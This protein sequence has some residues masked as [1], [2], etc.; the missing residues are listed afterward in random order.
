MKPTNFRNNGRAFEG[1]VE[2]ILTHYAGAGLLRLKKVEPPTRTFGGA[3][4]RQVVYLAN[5]FLDFIGA[6]TEAGGR[7]VCLEV[8]STQENRLPMG[9][10][11]GLSGTQVETIF[12]WENAGAVVAVIWECPEGVFMVRPAGVRRAIAAGRKSLKPEDGLRVPRG[13]GWVVWDFLSLLRVVY[14]VG[15]KVTVGD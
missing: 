14:G 7:T 10:T 9:G 12:H 8:K 5:P 4:R 15:E 6:W 2:T 11:S 1:L 13:T 3:G